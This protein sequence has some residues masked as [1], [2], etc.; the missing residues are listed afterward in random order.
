M[1]STTLGRQR[2]RTRQLGEQTF[3][4][5]ER[6]DE[7]LRKQWRAVLLLKS[8]EVKTMDASH[9]EKVD[10]SPVVSQD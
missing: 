2:A 4:A 8:T 3:V 10:Q 9:S 6:A 5:H 7:V 1:G